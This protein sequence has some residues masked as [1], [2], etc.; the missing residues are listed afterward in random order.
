[1]SAKS[2]P[3]AAIRPNP[4]PEPERLASIDR[5][6]ARAAAGKPLEGDD[7]PEVKVSHDMPRSL[8]HALR[9]AALDRGKKQ[10][11]LIREGLAAI[12]IVGK[13]KP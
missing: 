6:V 13:G 7:D 3:K 10:K 5:L 12:G 11:T 4:P 9:Q 2:F 1:M 8:Q